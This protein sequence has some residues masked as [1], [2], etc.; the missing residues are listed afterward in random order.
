MLSAL[1]LRPKVMSS[2]SQSISKWPKKRTRSVEEWGLSGAL[3][4]LALLLGV[5][6]R[7][8]G[9]C[10]W[11]SSSM[12][13]TAVWRTVSGTAPL[14]LKAPTIAPS[15]VRKISKSGSLSR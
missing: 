12:V 11:S 5:W 7:S 1:P 8:A 13:S 9:G 3:L 6:L 10:H 2:S 14:A 15:S 4:Q